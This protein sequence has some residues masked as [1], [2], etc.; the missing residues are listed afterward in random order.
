MG[1]VFIGSNATDFKMVQIL[2]WSVVD[3]DIFAAMNSEAD[4]PDR[5]E[6][7]TRK[8]IQTRRSVTRRNSSSGLGSKSLFT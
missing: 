5:R 2:E 8:S 4:E 3:G 1:S 6:G 7:G